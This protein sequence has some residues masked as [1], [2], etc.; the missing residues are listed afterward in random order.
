MKKILYIS[1]D[2][3]TDP[4]GQSQIL[5]YLKELSKYEFQFSVLSFEKKNRYHKESKTVEDITDAAGINWTPL[6]FTSKPPFLSKIYDRWKLKRTALKMYRRQKFDMVHCR[7]YVA[8]EIGL[9]FKKKFGTKFLFDMRGFWADEKKDSSWNVANPVYRAIYN[10][11]KKREKEYLNNAD[12]IVSLTEAGKMEMM[13]WPAYN[14][15]IPIEVI[16]T[17]TDID[18]FTLTSKE[19]KKES[20]QSL[21]ISNGTLVISYLGSVGTWYMLD[22]MLLFFRHVKKKYPDGVFLF[23]TP[24]ER[25][26]IEQKIKILGLNIEDFIIT[27]ASRKD[28]PFLVKAS[29][30]N[31]SFIKPVY[32]KIS[33]SPTKLGEVLAMGIPVICNSGVGDVETIIKKINAGFIFRE[34][35]DTAYTSAVNAIPGLLEKSSLDIRNGIKDICSLEKGV[36]SYL[37]C[38]RQLLP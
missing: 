12:C 25:F 18:H 38:Y 17:C 29:D 37:S 14:P 3:L 24:T 27:E 26:F 23:I 8:A 33:S 34:F 2:G 1:Y 16:P 30:I 13:R 21:G 6:W 22:E 36:Q 19:Q 31:V 4:L 7:S 11:Y 10:F 15:S 28:V 32:S 20:R 9:M 35:S 5:P